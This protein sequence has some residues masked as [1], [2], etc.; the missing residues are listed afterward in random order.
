MSVYSK[1]WMVM[2]SESGTLIAVREKLYFLPGALVGTDVHV[3]PQAREEERRFGGV[4]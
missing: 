3:T 4:S 2:S 1:K